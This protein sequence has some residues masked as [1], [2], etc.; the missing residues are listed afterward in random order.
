MYNEEL[1]GDVVASI[2]EKT[3]MNMGINTYTEVRNILADQ[4]LS[5]SDCYR[6]PSALNFALKQAFSDM[7]LSVIEK[8]RDE[9]GGLANDDKNLAAFLHKLSM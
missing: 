5:F 6:N 4:N 8:I 1:L 7:H 9:F 2:V 3:L